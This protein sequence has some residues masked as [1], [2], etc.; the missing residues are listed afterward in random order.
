[1]KYGIHYHK[2][3]L[4]LPYMYKEIETDDIENWIKETEQ[5]NPNITIMEYYSKEQTL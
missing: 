2:E 3:G 4:F 1:M 5:D